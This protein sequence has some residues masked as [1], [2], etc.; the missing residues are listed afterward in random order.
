VSRINNDQMSAAVWLALGLT[1]TGASVPYG[2]GT[3][4]SPG[5]G[6]LPFLSGLA[7]TLFSSI[8][9]GHA[10]LKRRMGVGWKP[11]MRGVIWKK[12]LIVLVALLAYGLLLKPL[13]FF[14]CTALFIGFLLRA[15]Q[16]QRWPVVMTGA[17]GAA[18]GAYGIFEAW[19]KAQLPRG[20]WGF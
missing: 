17:I 7:I 3:L 13:G 20:P 2:L 14:L 4:D 6:F 1:I 9:L 11:V 16:P 5:T 12:S 8:G 10:T 18:T 15:V 19:L